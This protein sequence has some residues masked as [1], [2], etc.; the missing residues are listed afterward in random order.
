MSKAKVPKSSKISS[1]ASVVRR[2]WQKQKSETTREAILEAAM[3]CFIDYG[4]AKTSVP[5]IAEEAGMSRGAVVH[6][7][8][9]RHDLLVAVVKYLHELRIKQYSEIMRDI[10]RPTE[11]IDREQHTKGVRAAWEHINLPSFVAY[12]ELLAAARTDE[13]LWGVM[14]PFEREFEKQFMFAAKEVLL[15]L[16]RRVYPTTCLSSS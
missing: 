16:P 15:D 5:L 9:T 12:K 7:F 3:R 10:D 14:A 1:K 4:Y 8:P 2:R 6:H 13:E 11:E